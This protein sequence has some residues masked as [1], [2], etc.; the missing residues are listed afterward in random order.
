MKFRHYRMLQLPFSFDFRQMFVPEQ[1]KGVQ[2]NYCI[3][4]T[5]VTYTFIVIKFKKETEFVGLLPSV[6]NFLHNFSVK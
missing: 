4:I 6:M 3:L 5:F 2:A 1:L